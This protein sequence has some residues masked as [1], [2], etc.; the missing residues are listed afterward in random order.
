MIG[1]GT[2]A[3]LVVAALIM[4]HALAASG[5]TDPFP[6]IPDTPPETSS[7][8][9]LAKFME[10]P[11]RVRRNAFASAAMAYTKNN[12]SDQVA[13]ANLQAPAQIYRLHPHAVTPIEAVDIVGFYYG[14]RLMNGNLPTFLEALAEELTLGWYDALR[15]TD[16]SGRNEISANEGFFAR[17]L[18]L[19]GKAFTQRF[20]E[21]MESQSSA[22]ADAVARGI[23]RARTAKDKVT[24]DVRWPS[25]YGLHQF[26]CTAP[27]QNCA[28][29]EA[30]RGQWDALFEQSAAR[31]TAYFSK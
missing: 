14:P 13:A 23:A 6:T 16:E 21:F 15:F 30:S 11:W 22:A 29:S 7:P 31:V 10:T 25:V 26:T 1:R 8:A 9:A 12:G 20:T 28:P 19:P 3:A 2:Q 5:Q 24:Y 4:V 18:V 17:A 27:A